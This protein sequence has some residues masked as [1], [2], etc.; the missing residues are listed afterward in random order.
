MGNRQK[1]NF[2][3]HW[4]FIPQDSPDFMETNLNESE[5]QAVSLPHS[6]KMHPHNY[7]DERDYQFI[8][9]YRRHFKLDNSFRGQRIVVEF[10]GAMT[11]AEVFLNEKRIGEHKG[12]YTAFTVDLTEHINWDGD[13]V[14]AVRLDSTNRPDVPPEGQIVDYMLFGGIYRNVNLIITDHIYID[15]VFASC[16][17]V[18]EESA[19]LNVVVNIKNNQNQASRV[20][21]KNILSGNNI[22]A[23]E[24]SSEVFELGAG[25]SKEVELSCFINYPHLWNLDNPFLYNLE[26]QLS[27]NSGDN[28]ETRIG[29]RSIR[30]NEDGIFELNGE[31]IKLTGHNRHQNF[32]YLGGAMCDRYQ[33]EDADVLKNEL[34]CNFMRTSHYPQ[35]KSF[36]DRCDEIG[37]L[38]FEELPG[39]Q[40]I[41]DEAWKD[42]CY[43]NITDMIVRDRNHPSIIMWG[44]RI[45]E[46][47]DDDEFYTA[48]N[49]LS[50]TL[51]STRCTTGVRYLRESSF[52]EDVYGFNDYHLA[53][54][55]ELR[56]PNYKPYFVSEYMGVMFPTKSYDNIG[57]QIENARRHASS[58]NAFYRTPDMAGA[59]GWSAFDYNTHLQFGHGDRVCYHGLTDIFRI[60]KLSA[61]VH[62]SQ[63]DP[64][65][66]IVLFIAKYLVPALFED[67][68]ELD[69]G[70][71][72]RTYVYSNCEE[73]ELFF[74]G[75]S[76]GRIKGD[77]EEFPYLP[78]PPF[79]FELPYSFQGM[80]R[81]TNLTAVGYI[82]GI[83]VARHVRHISG[84][85][86]S[87]KLEADYETITADGSDLT[88]V[89]VS[90]VDELGQFMPF[91]QLPVSFSIS[92]N[93]RLIGENPLS[94]EG[95]RAAVYVQ[96]TLEPGEIILRANCRD[97]TSYEIK[98]NTIRSSDIY[99]SE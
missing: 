74:E 44:V 24:L 40:F 42:L 26:T 18:S 7:F 22:R 69:K 17:D 16:Q 96:G 95:G 85:A 29:I 81:N 35:A 19:K 62:K 58:L 93:G 66:E 10:E 67:H 76:I 9:W 71:R 32:P 31:K 77:D 80:T 8:S 14:L 38:V 65:K 54:K 15:W 48:T 2:N 11:V 47:L 5:F 98:I 87:V 60:P 79:V 92:G 86:T 63:I 55:G 73:V 28:V 61:I 91:C 59:C 72:G 30:F 12:G 64:G 36:I 53:H 21:L 13:N 88:R 82:G 43:K 68:E 78:H 90:I 84:R 45:N 25:E 39:W 49:K 89:V 46:S 94:L 34:G 27:G 37:L 75:E 52:L 83:E 33:R 1:L 51:D 70:Y 4:L 20:S 41:G 23:C 97:L 3:T 57:R 6:N 50:H 99:V 56:R